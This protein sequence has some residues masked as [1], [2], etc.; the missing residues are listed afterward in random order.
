MTWKIIKNGADCNSLLRFFLFSLR[1]R[2]SDFLV[3][4][5]PGVHIVVQCLRDNILQEDAF[6]KGNVLHLTDQIRIHDEGGSDFLG[7]LG[8]FGWLAFL[9][10]THILPAF[11]F[12]F[13]LHFLCG[14][15]CRNFTLNGC[16]PGYS[17]LLLLNFFG[18]SLFLS[19]FNLLF[20]RRFLCLVGWNGFTHEAIH[21]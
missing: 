11:G 6:H 21:P 17:M 4:L 9:G 7:L 5:L 14:S 19:L 10:A 12:E 16:F 1:F 15:R 18:Y 3:L 20:L 13:G 8:T 2:Q